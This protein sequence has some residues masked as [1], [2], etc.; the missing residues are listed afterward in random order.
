MPVKKNIFI[1]T[2]ITMDSFHHYPL[3]ATKIYFSQEIYENWR[4][5]LTTGCKK[6]SVKSTFK[7][8][9]LIWLRFLI[10]YC[11][12]AAANLAIGT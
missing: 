2:K 9:S 12:L 8:L 10:P 6:A 7:I 4:L 5:F 1:K 3:F 11:G